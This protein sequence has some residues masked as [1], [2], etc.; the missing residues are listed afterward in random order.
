MLQMAVR[1]ILVIMLLGIL[2]NC[3][4]RNGALVTLNGTIRVIGNEPLVYVVIRTGTAEDQDRDFLITGPLTGELRHDFQGKV[5][6]LI[7]KICSS[8]VPQI[9]KCLKPTKIIVE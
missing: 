8:P 4:S 9:N 2:P 1:I 6:T 7:G 3:A 5:V